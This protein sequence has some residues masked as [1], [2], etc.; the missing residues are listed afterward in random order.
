[1]PLLF[2]SIVLLYTFNATGISELFSFAKTLS[3]FSQFF[4]LF[5]NN[6]GT[7]RIFKTYTIRADP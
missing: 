7:V 1:M 3:G 2:C 6:V 5:V 4:V